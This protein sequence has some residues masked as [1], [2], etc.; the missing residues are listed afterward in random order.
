[1]IMNH[2]VANIQRQGLI[3]VDDHEVVAAIDKEERAYTSSH[4]S[5][6]K[7][8]EFPHKEKELDDGNEGLENNQRNVK[9]AEQERASQQSSIIIETSDPLASSSN[10]NYHR[11]LEPK[12]SVV[13]PSNH[14]SLA[15]PTIITSDHGQFVQATGI[16][17]HTPTPTHLL[18]SLIQLNGQEGMGLFTGLQSC[19]P[20]SAE[21]L[22]TTNG[23]NPFFWNVAPV[24]SAEQIVASDQLT[25]DERREEL[26]CRQAASGQMSSQAKERRKQQQQLSKLALDHIQSTNPMLLSP[27]LFLSPEQESFLR[28]AQ[29]QQ[30]HPLAGKTA[31]DHLVETEQQKVYNQ[32]AR[33]ALTVGEV[34][35]TLAFQQQQQQQ[36]QEQRQQQFQL[37]QDLTAQNSNQTLA[38]HQIS[39]QHHLNNHQSHLAGNAASLAQNNHYYHAQLNNQ[40]QQQQKQLI[41]PQQTYS[42]QPQQHQQ[43]QTLFRPTTESHQVLYASKQVDL[44]NNPN[45]VQP[46]AA[47]HQLNGSTPGEQ[48]LIELHHHHHHQQQQPLGCS[49]IQDPSQIQQQLFYAQQQQQQHQVGYQQLGQQDTHRRYILCNQQVRAPLRPEAPEPSQYSS[50]QASFLNSSVSTSSCSSLKDDVLSSSSPHIRQGQSNQSLKAN[51]IDEQTGIA[52]EQVASPSSTA[53]LKSVAQSPADLLA[54]DISQATII[55]PA[56]QA[57]A[58][59]TNGKKEPNRSISNSTSATN[60][61]GVIVKKKSK[62]GRKKKLISDEEMIVR[63]NRSKERN[64]VAAKRCR[65]KRKQFLDELRAKIDNLNDLNRKLQKENTQIR[66]ELELLKHHHKNAKT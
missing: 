4:A 62:G 56:N 33:Q 53:T 9:L 36:Q 49:P 23:I 1:M 5:E 18:S 17:N 48:R 28:F 34:N 30:Q 52:H 31:H 26:S 50:Q 19:T 16:T 21:G 40:Q 29:Q 35:S 25:T 60:I 3:N 47:H 12:L 59:Q 65:Q 7:N 63:K 51:P 20:T 46:P 2:Q 42:H 11:Q 66:N 37:A 22:V 58:K 8:D 61:E 15:T 45:S 57:K 43:T 13:L 41:S 44:N 64:R 39:Q 32:A 55:D 10:R 27:L 54:D 6:A 24:S 38:Y 14:K